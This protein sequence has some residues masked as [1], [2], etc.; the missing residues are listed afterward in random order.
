MSWK[1]GFVQGNATCPSTPRGMST[2][3]FL[4]RLTFK[5]ASTSSAGCWIV[6]GKTENSRDLR[7][8]VE[9]CFQRTFSAAMWRER[10]ATAQ[11]IGRSRG[12]RTTKI[13]AICDRIGRLRV[14]RLSA[15]NVADITAAP[16]LLA[17]APLSEVFLGDQG[18]DARAFRQ[19]IAARGA[20]VVIP[21]NPTRKHP[22][23]FDPKPYR[24]QCH[25][26][27]VLPAQRLAASRHATTSSLKI[28]HR[29]WRS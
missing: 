20:I 19:S 23:P 12:G 11:A 14:F 16:D 1:L 3:W 25:R 18:Y 22:H 13:H 28:L 10:G 2:V 24:M 8:R 5:A 21:N 6:P 15:G 4:E 29:L 7:S 17:A 27:D 26:T 9:L